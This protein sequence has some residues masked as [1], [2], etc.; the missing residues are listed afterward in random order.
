MP[1]TIIIGAQ[2][3]DEGKG[4]VVDYFAA[5]ADIVARYNGGDNAGHTIVAEGHKLALHL[6]PSGI[7]YPDKICLIGAGTVVNPLTLLEEM[8]TLRQIGIKVTPDQLKLA[9][10]AQLLLPTHRSLDGASELHRG[11]QAI[12]TT[13]RGIGPAY[14]DKARRTGL[15]AALMRDPNAFADAAQALI[16][17]HNQQLN[18]LYGLKPSLVG[19][20]VQ[21]L[22]EAAEQLAPYLTDGT[23]LINEAL[24]E[25]KHVLC[26]G[27]QGTLL[28][29]DHG[30][31]PFVTSSF[32]I[33]G[34]ALTGL[35]FGPKEVTRVV[36]VAKA[37]T[38]RVGAGPFPSELED[39]TGE[40]LRKVGREYGTTTGRPRRCGWLDSVIL[41]YAAQVNGLDEF[42]L[43]KLD[44]LSGLPTLRIVVAYDLYGERVEHF[45]A[46]WGADVL[47]R[48]KPIYEDMPGWEEDIAGV[49]RREELPANAQAY[50]ARIEALA[51]VPVTFIGVGPEREAMVVP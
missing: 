28:D 33:S 45:P 40:H 34:G 5:Q 16:E 7:L 44:I 21:Q 30:T 36:G 15:R 31:Y 48:C 14:A 50:V 1:A 47:D 23:T 11:R 19:P 51:G 43:T 17:A 42:A 9:A 41:H 12:G 27:A 39:E 4:H 24:A 32:P 38:T 18:Q 29:I 25:G 13:Q 37:Y 10:G 6:V 8:E 26:E 3:G 2:W 35:G 49:R 22:R 46:E 20:M